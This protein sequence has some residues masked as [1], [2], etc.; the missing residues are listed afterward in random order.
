MWVRVCFRA[1]VLAH[2]H[3]V[4][5][6]LNL[7]CEARLEGCAAGSDHG[8]IPA[9]L[10]QQFS[11]LTYMDFCVHNDGVH[12]AQESVRETLIGPTGA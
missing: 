6:G 5:K 2:M 3:L 10:K 12:T 9:E 4:A 1:D 11:V 7:S 8:R